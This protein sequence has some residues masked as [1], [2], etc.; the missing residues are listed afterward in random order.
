[1]SGLNILGAFVQVIGVSVALIGAWRSWQR[2]G[3]EGL[4]DPVMLPIRRAARRVWVGLE[5][6]A[7]RLLRR[8][9]HKEAHAGVAM[10]LGVALNARGRKQFRVLP[11]DLDPTA[12]IGELD[13]RTRELMDRAN[14]LRDQ[15]ADE[16]AL[17]RQEAAG[18]ADRLS[19]TRQELEARDRAIAR[20][21]IRLQFVGL[22]LVLAG[23]VL[24]VQPFV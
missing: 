4:A 1:V 22:A 18:I 24:Q 23:F 16:T 12:A 7:R 11:G 8:P 5:R 15:L 10:G 20:D 14:D 9:V 17:I 6:V 19:Q 3:D 13:E 2:F 21:G